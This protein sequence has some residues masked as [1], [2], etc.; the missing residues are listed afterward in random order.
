MYQPSSSIP[1]EIP[2]EKMAYCYIST[3]N[4]APDSL[5]YLIIKWEA[6][7]PNNCKMMWQQKTK[8]H[9]FHSFQS[10]RKRLQHLLQ[11][12]EGR[13]N[14][15]VIMD[16]KYPGNNIS[17]ALLQSVTDNRMEILVLTTHAIYYHSSKYTYVGY[18]T[19]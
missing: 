8:Y 12:P 2:L 10:E 7:L 9:S 1:V 5:V 16:R 19:R 13:G 18:T 15:Q 11:E 4:C 6:S 14:T 17:K 3:A